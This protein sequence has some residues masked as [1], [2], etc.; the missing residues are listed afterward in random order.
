MCQKVQ[1]KT[2][3]IL[4]QIQVKN[5]LN[6]FESIINELNGCNEFWFS[7]AFVTAG[8]VASLKNTLEEISNR[9]IKGKILV[10]QYLNFTQPEALRQ[11]LKFKNIE[12]RISV[13]TNFH[14]KGYLFK[15]HDYY[16]LII[17]SSNLTGD[18]LSLL[19]D[20][21]FSKITELLGVCSLEQDLFNI[22]KSIFCMFLLAGEKKLVIFFAI[23]PDID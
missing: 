8:G 14:A 10:S 7:V 20:Y 6:L 16:N 3:I 21:S 18:A 9:N 1:I 15:K 23:Y 11:L 13:N 12:L 22:S 2:H 4:S 17:G 19:G 5:I